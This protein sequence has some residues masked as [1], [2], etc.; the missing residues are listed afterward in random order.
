SRTIAST[1]AAT[2]TA[3][4]NS[5]SRRIGPGGFATRGAAQYGRLVSRTTDQA[6]GNRCW[7]EPAERTI[8]EVA[9][10]VAPKWPLYRC[11]NRASS[12]GWLHADVADR[13]PSRP[14]SF[15]HG[16][17]RGCGAA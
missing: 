1:T 2:I 4:T 8:R 12:R 3:A 16:S 17:P 5:Q 10:M 15:R 9:G 14:T 11:A 13:R 6:Y 7:G